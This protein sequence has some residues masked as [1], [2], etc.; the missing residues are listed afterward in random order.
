MEDVIVEVD[1][2][3]CRVR[4]DSDK[5]KRW[6]QGNFD[7]V[8]IVVD[9]WHCA[10]HVRAIEAEGMS[11]TPGT[12]AAITRTKRRLLGS[13]DPER[14]VRPLRRR[15]TALAS[16]LKGGRAGS[17][18]GDEAI[19]AAGLEMKVI[20]LFSAMLISVVLCLRLW[21]VLESLLTDIRQWW[22]A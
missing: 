18:G 20:K 21:H 3:R 12:L 22:V 7:C 8:E 16:R 15:L 6:G 4:F 10:N 2:A 13:I 17:Y 14:P 5:A 11:V 9:I 19:T 1:G